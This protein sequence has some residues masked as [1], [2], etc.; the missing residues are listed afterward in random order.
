MN[1]LHCVLA[2]MAVLA[3]VATGSNERQSTGHEPALGVYQGAGCDGVKHL[4]N[5]EQWFGGK[6]DQVVDF[7]SWSVFKAGTTWGMRCW[8]EAG[9]K[10]VVYSV[11]MLPPDHS[12]TL[13]DGAAGHFDDLFTAYAQHL[14]QY[15][16][17]G[18]VIRIGWEF[19]GN[20][21]PWSAAKDPQAWIEYWRRIVRTMRAVPGAH[22]RFDW[23]AAASGQFRAEDAYPGDEYVDIIGLDFYNILWSRDPITPEARWQKR[24]HAPNG[25]L[26]HR[27]FAGDHHKPMSY[28]EWGTGLRPDGRGGGDDPYYVEQMAKWIADNNVEYHN[29]WDFV[30]SDFNAKLSDQHQPDSAAAFKRVFS[31]KRN[32]E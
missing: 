2:V 27:Q 20:W 18:S 25:L 13:A 26:W 21:F 5:F 10:N 9:Q 3:A 15:G 8:S 4:Q 17:G 7:V 30:A 19:N 11:P 29:Y 14:V 1:A 24:L 23:N 16:Y 31:A 12:A 6:P 28:P 32:A 22:F